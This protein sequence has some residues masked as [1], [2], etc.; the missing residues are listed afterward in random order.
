MRYL[1]LLMVL[2]AWVA[3]KKTK[4]ISFEPIGYIIAPGTIID[5]GFSKFGLGSYPKEKFY[6]NIDN[7]PVDSFG[8]IINISDCRVIKK[9]KQ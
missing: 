3:V 9:S 7:M 8:R 6:I 1:I 5:S 2:T 4:T